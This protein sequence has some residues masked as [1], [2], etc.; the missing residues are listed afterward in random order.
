MPF[1]AVPMAPELTRKYID[2][3]RACVVFYVAFISLFVFLSLP[4]SFSEELNIDRLESSGVPHVFSCSADVV[5]Q[6][7]V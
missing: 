3:A 2:L 4:F 5:R 1:E 6:V 7:A